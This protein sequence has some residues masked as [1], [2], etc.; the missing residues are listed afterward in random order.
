M[1]LRSLRE[2]VPPYFAMTAAADIA[3]VGAGAAGLAAAIFAGQSLR[4]QGRTDARIVLLESAQRVGAKILISGGGRCNVTHETVRVPDFNFGGSP[5]VVRN[6]LRAFDEQAT[7]RWFESLGVPLKREETGKLF[8]V[9]DRARSV[10]DVLLRRCDELGVALLTDHRVGEVVRDGE[11]FVVRHSQG[12]LTARH[13]VLA[14]GGRSVPKTGSDGHGWEI[15]RSLGHTVT[16]TYPALSPLVLDPSFFHARL[17][18]VSHEVELTTLVDGRPIDRRRGALLW[19]H[20]GCSGPVVLDA[21]RFWIIAQAEG[22]KPDLRCN[23]LGSSRH[24][25]CAVERNSFRSGL[26]DQRRADDGDER[27]EF[28][29]TAEAD[30]WLVETAAREARR[31]VA[32]VLAEVLPHRVAEEIASFAGISPEQP[33]GQLAKEQR[34]Q[35]ARLLT[36]LRLPVTGDRGWNY[37][38]V[39]AG[40]VPLAE[41]DYRTMQ[42]RLL[43]GLYLIGEMLDCE[44]RIG[45]FNFQW[46]WATGHV[47]GTAVAR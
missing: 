38:E 11:R 37:A 31:T 47:A 42:S 4:E 44:G 16:P 28:R 23:V 46:A 8:P 45:G 41:I 20:F 2:L 15:A 32:G 43:P 14:T 7:V 27:N 30:R 24:T 21:S 12:E 22:R 25:P 29:S 10:L 36:E 3:I 19:T 6:I 35:L 40:G 26:A 13:V 1:G 18:G 5:N 39:T 34:K 9:S 17:S 33:I